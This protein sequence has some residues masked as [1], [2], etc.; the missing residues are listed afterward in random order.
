MKEHTTF[1]KKLR[2]T[3]EAV[4]EVLKEGPISQGLQDNITAIWK[5]LLET[6]VGI[7]S[8]MALNE[9]EVKTE[10][11]K[12]VTSKFYLK[13]TYYQRFSN[14]ITRLQNEVVIPLCGLHRSITTMFPQNLSRSWQT[15]KR[16]VTESKCHIDK[17]LVRQTKEWLRPISWVEE[18]YQ[19]YVDNISSSDGEWFFL[20]QEYIDWYNQL[21][22]KSSPILCIS[23]VPGVPRTQIAA[24]VVQKLREDRRTVTYLFYAERTTASI[25]A[26]Q[27]IGTLCWNLLNQFPEDAELLPEVCKEDGE[28]TEIEIQTFLQRMCERRDAIIL[29]DG[30]DEC[31]IKTK[32]RGKLCQFLA[33]SNGVCDIIM[34]SQEL[35]DIKRNLSGYD[36]LLRITNCEA[37]FWNEIERI[38]T[39]CPA[40]LESWERKEQGGIDAGIKSCQVTKEHDIH[41]PGSKEDQYQVYA[42]LRHR[43]CDSRLPAHI[44]R[45]IID[46]AE[47][48]VESAFQRDEPLIVNGE[49]VK[50]NIP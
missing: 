39:R 48:W 50:R 26:R 10:N 38:P 35:E 36:S 3:L 8:S 42:M 16:W 47:Y 20:M 15:F 45:Q 9:G 12:S 33:S 5:H 18:R 40:G 31:S 29:L 43:I 22:K 2:N 13:T 19:A 23:G 17:R 24:R 1:L 14:K 6:E 27:L 41:F 49:K 32:E 21:S 44:A 46:E 30:L 7:V 34:F 11:M 25:D 37:D 28:P 4:K